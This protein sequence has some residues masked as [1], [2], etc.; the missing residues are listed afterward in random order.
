MEEKLRDLDDILLKL[1]KCFKKLSNLCDH[2]E[3]LAIEASRTRGAQWIHE[4]LWFTWSFDKFAVSIPLLL[5]PYHRALHK[6]KEL[7][8]A[9][10]P[11]STPF[12]KARTWISLWAAQEELKDDGWTDYWEDICKAEVRGWP[13]GMLPMG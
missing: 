9:L 5:I 3:E 6:H 8:E 1:D 2:I 12:E 10:R 4:P 13:D 11:H 7:V